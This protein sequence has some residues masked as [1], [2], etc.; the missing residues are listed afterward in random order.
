MGKK[1][2]D[3]VSVQYWEYRTISLCAIRT[4]SG[5]EMAYCKMESVP[6]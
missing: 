6:I 2:D 5:L 1:N 3:S 4:V